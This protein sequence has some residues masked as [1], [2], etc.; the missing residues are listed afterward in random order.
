MRANIISA[1]SL[2]FAMTLQASAAPTQNWKRALEL[3]LS[4]IDNRA[5]NLLDER[6]L[7]QRFMNKVNAF[8]KSPTVRAMGSA[9]GS[10]LLTAG[11]NRIFKRIPE[12][13]EPRGT[14]FEILSADCMLMR[15]TFKQG[16]FTELSA[17]DLELLEKLLQQREFDGS[18][19]PMKRELN[20]A[21]ELELNE[22][23]LNVLL[24]LVT[25][26]LELEELD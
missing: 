21:D 11:V 8:V 16:D 14:Y 24:K 20:P 19:G 3:D 22:R 15:D 12:T 17:R 23:D 18:I 6:G 9:V 13:E 26:G 5:F 1:G 10:T 7:G 25:R 2:A 4:E